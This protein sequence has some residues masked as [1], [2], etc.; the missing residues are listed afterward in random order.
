MIEIILEL[1]GTLRMAKSPERLGLDL[2]DAL[3]G[4]VEIQADFLEGERIAVI[5][6]EAHAQDF[7]LAGRKRREDAA[8][9]LLEELEGGLV[10]RIL[11]VLVFDEVPEKGI[12]F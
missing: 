3:A 4:N 11:D 9:L 8:Q 12:L 1:A 10:G 5:E 2:P 6:A 7:L